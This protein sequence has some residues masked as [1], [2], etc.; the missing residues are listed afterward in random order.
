M[1]TF[2]TYADY[3]LPLLEV[4][5]GLPDGQGTA[6]EVRDRFA[7]LFD[8]CIPDEHR[9]FIESAHVVKWCNIVAW[10]RSTFTKRGLMDAPIYGI[11]GITEAG[12]ACLQQARSS[13][14]LVGLPLTVRPSQALNRTVTYPIE[15]K[16]SAQQRKEAVVQKTQEDELTTAAFIDQV[17][18]ALE[19]QLAEL[20]PAATMQIPRDQLVQVHFPTFSGCHYEL[21]VHAR[22]IEFGLHFESSRKLNYA[23]VE[24]F[25]PYQDAL[26]HALSEQ[27]RIERWGQ[28]LAR[29][30]YELPKPPLTRALAADHAARLHRLITETLP[31][32]RELFAN[33]TERSRI[34]AHIETPTPAHVIVDTQIAGVRDFL[35]GRSSR[36]SDERLCDWVH[37]CYEFE[38]Y[39]EGRELFALIDP[40]QVN[41]WYYE[42]AKRLAK[43]CA[44]KV[45]GHA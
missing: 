41:P 16:L 45:A 25:L 39:R 18:V 26:T 33:Q 31:I 8:N 7:E 36:P 10:T 23:R 44:M 2:Q 43:V 5:A 29:V 35:N 40:T 22:S 1:Q 13:A 9:V 6:K 12:R 28:G 30:F 17:R 14:P 42:R 19:R 24:T 32:L 34:E 37:L 4:L 20:T 38:L 27:I 21:W 3:E 11:L 15:G